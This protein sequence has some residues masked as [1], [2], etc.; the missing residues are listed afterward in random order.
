MLGFLGYADMEGLVEDTVPESI[1]Y[2]K[3]LDLPAATPEHLLL[4]EI[5]AIAEENQVFRSYIGMGYYDTITPGIIGR[6][7][8]ENPGWYTQ[9]TPYQ[10][11][12]SQGRLEALLNFQTLIIDM[13]GL[14]IANSSLLDEGTAAAEAMA[15]FQSEAKGNRSTFFV[16][17][18]CH[19]QTIAVVQTRAEPVG[20]EVVVGDH[21]VF[22]F[23]DDVFGALVS[24]PTT[25]GQVLD[26]EGFANKAH[27]AGAF[28]VVAAD[29]MSL[30]LLKPPGEFGADAAVGN[31][32]RFGVPMGYGG[33]HA[34]YLAAREG[35]K[36]KMPG[37]IIGV[38]VDA[39]WNPALRM[40][41]QT[42]EQHIRREKATSN[43]CTAQVL[44]AIMASM[45]AVYH[46]P[47]GVRAIAQRIHNLAGVLSHGLRRLGH[48][49]VHDLFFDTIRVRP[50]GISANAVLEA[51]LDRGINLRDFGDGSI[52]IS[53]DEGVLPGDVN[54]LF[55]VFGAE[56]EVSAEA[57]AEE[58]V[59]VEFPGTFV[60]T[61]DYLT[62]PVFNRYHS[63]TEM[64]RYIHKLEARDLSL[65]TSMI[66]LGSC[67]MKLNA[68]TEMVPI[69]WSEF[70]NLHPFAPADQA[71]GYKRII[72]DL[73]AWL[74]EIT[75][76]TD[77]SMMPNSGANGEYTGLL[78]IRAY[79][80]D[81]GNG[82]RD[83]CLVPA[84]Q[85]TVPTQP[86]RS[87]PG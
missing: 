42:R 73:E 19:P 61:S 40:A 14:E 15:L 29:L 5:R 86:V 20:I 83:V 39:D 25:C 78:V 79:H 75:G 87:W 85:P 49:I 23:H 35:F 10:A 30:A 76:F 11:E 34:A 31:T 47:Q 44:L 16:S 4:K 33:P 3:D 2:R 60:R 70:A 77:T 13:T 53:L 51:A 64:L 18:L 74:E 38:S 55:S 68:T 72:Q 24:Y 1:R 45:Y 62:H 66:S 69:T 81:N 22:E 59:R 65:N 54:D 12:I 7:I 9:Y 80:L 32:Q 27:G 17:E 28:V 26:Y 67:T 43:I 82:H 46:G 58:G 8:L 41:L 48:E 50:Q 84:L 37:R 6:N 36:R 63:E 56:G 21:E 52:G 57:L 71:K